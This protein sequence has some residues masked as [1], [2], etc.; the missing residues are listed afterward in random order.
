MPDEGVGLEIEVSKFPLPGEL[1]PN[2]P[3]KCRDL[4]PRREFCVTFGKNP[5]TFSEMREFSR[6]RTNCLFGSLCRAD[7]A[8]DQ[9]TMPDEMGGTGIGVSKFSLFPGVL[10][11]R[12]G[13]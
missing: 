10:S 12:N 6:R 11:P 2:L 5:A 1:I 9:G 3:V 7:L 8:C 4:P 13:F